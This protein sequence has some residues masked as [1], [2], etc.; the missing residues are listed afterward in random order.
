[1]ILVLRSGMDFESLSESHEFCCL[2]QD[3]CEANYKPR[4][5]VVG[6]RAG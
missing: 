3:I 6:G 4:L 2:L 1:M 5:E